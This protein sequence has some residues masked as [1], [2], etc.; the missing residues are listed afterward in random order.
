MNNILIFRI[1]V[2]HCSR[3]Y[4]GSEETAECGIP[5]GLGGGQGD[6]TRQVP[7]HPQ[8]QKAKVSENTLNTLECVLLPYCGLNIWKQCK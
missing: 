4:R 8:Q 5:A 7:P 3:D 1:S 2:T 6:D